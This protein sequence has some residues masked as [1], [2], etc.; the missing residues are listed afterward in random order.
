MKK[1]FMKPMAQLVCLNVNDCMN[2]SGDNPAYE[3]QL[4]LWDENLSDG[5]GL[6]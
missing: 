1:S 6:K 5:A 4:S 2:T 3:N